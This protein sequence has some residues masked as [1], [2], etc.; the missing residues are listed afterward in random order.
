[1]EALPSVFASGWASGVNA[2]LTVLVLGVADRIGDYAAIPD[3]LGHWVVITIASVM[4]VIEFIADKIPYLDSAWDAVSTLVRPATGALLGVLLA[5]EGT[6]LNQ[7]L[8]GITGG[9]TALASHT[10]KSGE[11]LAINASPEPA[12]NVVVSLLED[13]AVFGV[14]YVAVEHPYVGAGIAAALLAIG[15]VILVVVIK[16]ARR[17]LNRLSRRRESPVAGTG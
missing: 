3:V 9:T 16:L 6:D 17:G 1:M 14:M 15:L 11:R 13:V 5:G 10:V 7:V 4:Y 2:Y 8:A 12:S